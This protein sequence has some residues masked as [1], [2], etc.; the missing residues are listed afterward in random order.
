[1]SASACGYGYTVR[2]TRSLATG[3]AALA[4]SACSSPSTPP[5][6]AT[7]SPAPAAVP[8]LNTSYN[9]L[10]VAWVDNASHVLWDVEKPGF[11]PKNDADWTEIED[12]AIQLA[13]AGTLI[14]L[15][16]NGVSD[17]IWAKAADWQANA[18]AMAEAGKAAFDAAKKRSLPA[19]VEANGALVRACVD[20]HRQYKPELPT[21]GITHQRPHSESHK[22]N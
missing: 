2:W 21:E 13:A 10:M 16:G 5:Q 19:L 20:C 4:L 18:R 12:H 15:P 22:G 14:Q 8:A 17:P 7:T 6:Q 3:V 1:M 11:E 9:Q